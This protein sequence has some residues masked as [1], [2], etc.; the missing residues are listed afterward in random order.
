MIKSLHQCQTPGLIQRYP[1]INRIKICLDHRQLHGPRTV[2]TARKLIQGD[3]NEWGCLMRVPP[4]NIQIGR[5]MTLEYCQS[6]EYWEEYGRPAGKKEGEGEKKNEGGGSPSDKLEVNGDR[7]SSSESS[8]SHGDR[9]SDPSDRS[10]C[11]SNS[12]SDLD[13][14]EKSLRNRVR[15]RIKHNQ[16]RA[17]T[18]IMGTTKSHRREKRTR[19]ANRDR[20]GSA[21]ENV[22]ESR[23][24]DS[25][26]DS[27]ARYEDK[28]PVNHYFVKRATARELLGGSAPLREDV[29]MRPEEFEMS[30]TPSSYLGK[31]LGKG[32]N[33]NAPAKKKIVCRDSAK[34]SSITEFDFVVKDK[35]LEAHFGNSRNSCTHP[36][37]LAQ[38]AD[39]NARLKTSI[40]KTNKTVVVC[41]GASQGEPE[42]VGQMRQVMQKLS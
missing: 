17:E 5:I 35:S 6:D 39:E 41:F 38:K 3:Y 36:P 18:I 21:L 22:L 4:K 12:D 28:L 26:R 24:G 7:D 25:S 19:P 2:E 13:P 40:H 30:V 10:G 27:I 42:W 32:K 23:Y 9:S 29:I 33:S 14:E 37:Y 34:N 8:P 31:G 20:S 1:C 11:G 15:D 16:A